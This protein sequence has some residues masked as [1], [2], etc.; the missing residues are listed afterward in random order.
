LSL[1]SPLLR[2]L[3]EKNKQLSFLA[4]VPPR[5]FYV[6]GLVDAV[7]LAADFICW[8]ES[9]NNSWLP[10]Q[11]QPEIQLQQELGLDMFS[12]CQHPYLLDPQASPHADD[13]D[14]EGHATSLATPS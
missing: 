7:D 9:R 4:Q 14:A 11:L 2:M 10:E 5:E 8:S 13:R 1:L 3:S 12:F 6:E